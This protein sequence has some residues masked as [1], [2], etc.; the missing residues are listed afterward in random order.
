MFAS[1][2]FLQSLIC[3]KRINEQHRKKKREVYLM[4]G[5]DMH[6]TYV[7]PTSPTKEQ[8]CI[9]WDSSKF[10]NNFLSW[11]IRL[12]RAWSSATKPPLH[13]YLEDMIYLNLCSKKPISISPAHVQA[14]SL[15]NQYLPVVIIQAGIH[16]IIILY[17][18]NRKVLWYL[19]G[20]RLMK[21]SYGSCQISQYFENKK[22]LSLNKVLKHFPLWGGVMVSLCIYLYSGSRNI[23]SKL[24]Q[25]LSTL[26][27]STSH[28]RLYSFT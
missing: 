5:I 18:V 19:Q 2:T 13:M 22:T 25:V 1:Y 9:S 7:I 14:G 4:E 26:H 3:N 16:F 10:N 27:C 12:G 6:K 24:P 15:L 11:E 23:F 8:V 17:S 20:G 21:V 28:A